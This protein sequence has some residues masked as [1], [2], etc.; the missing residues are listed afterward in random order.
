MF[1][2]CITITRVVHNNTVNLRMSEF[3]LL[4]VMGS[5]LLMTHNNGLMNYFYLL[6]VMGCLN[7]ATINNGSS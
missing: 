1:M 6:T 7:F 2:V 3:A 5:I 4:T